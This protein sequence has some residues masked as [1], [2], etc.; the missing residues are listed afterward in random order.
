[1]LTSVSKVT[2]LKYDKDEEMVP[3]NEF[4]EKPVAKETLLQAIKKYIK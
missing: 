1:M 4:F 2:G 3:V